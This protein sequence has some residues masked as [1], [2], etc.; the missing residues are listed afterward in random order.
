MVSVTMAG[1]VQKEISALNKD[2]S[3]NTVK[4]RI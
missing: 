3:S 2:L 1:Q 4:T